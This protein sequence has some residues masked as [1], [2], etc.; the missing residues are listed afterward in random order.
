MSASVSAT[1]RDAM[2]VDGISVVRSTTVY[3]DGVVRKGKGGDTALAVAKIG[4]LTTRTD[5]DTGTLTMNGGHG[6]TTGVRLDVYWTESGVKGARYGMTVGTVAGDSVPIDGGGG[7]NLPTNTTAVTAQVPAEEELLFTGNNVQF[8]FAK[9]DR[10]GIIVFATSA[11]ATVKAVVDPLEGDTGGGWVWDTENGLTNPF[12]GA[13]VAKVF[14]SNG[15]SS[16]TNTMVAGA[17]VN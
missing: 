8:A 11:P 9:S 3:A 2:E 6:I 10:R 4:Q 17:G 15:D 13:S 14:F 5:N 7:D 16:N 1:I 12:A